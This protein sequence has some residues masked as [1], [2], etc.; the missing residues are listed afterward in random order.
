MV[1]LLSFMVAFLAIPPLIH[2]LQKWQLGQIIR[3]EGPSSHLLKTGTPT[4]GGMIFVAIALL[5]VCL[6]ILLKRS[7]PSLLWGG[8][9]IVAYSLVGFLDDFLKKIKKSAY[10]LKAREDISLQI[11]LAIP[12]LLYLLYSRSS[13]VTVWIW[14]PFKLFLILA[15]T[16]SV[17]LT[18]GLDGLLTGISLLIFAFFIIIGYLFSWQT[19]LNP[20][21]LYVLS[22]TLLA[23][24]YYNVYPAKVFMGNMGSFALGGF[25]AFLVLWTD[26]DWLFLILGGLFFTEAVSVILQVSYFKYTRKKTG[27]GKRIF[28]M[29]PIH[30]HFELMQIPESTITV[31]FWLLQTLL[32]IISLFL[33]TNGYGI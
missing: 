15:I 6:C 13:P 14:L 22:G 28:K 23:F 12:F 4:M 3:E 11:L 9:M 21:L 24:L 17:N 8:Y 30:H 16:N 27:S 26:I 1:V 18:D 20:I 31:R 10:G 33:Y 7:D 25:I 2:S 29:A 32:T 19:Q 5:T